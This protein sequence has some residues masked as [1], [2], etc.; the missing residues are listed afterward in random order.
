[1]NISSSSPRKRGPSRLQGREA[2]VFGQVSPGEVVA[3]DQ[4]E[5]P[6]AQPFLDALLAGD[7]V[8]HRAVRFEPDQPLDAVPVG[9]TRRQGFAV[10]MEAADQVGSD[11]GVERAVATG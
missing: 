11:A 1:A 6:D 7:R 5:L 2:E 3:F 9:E 4:F 8:F 10:L